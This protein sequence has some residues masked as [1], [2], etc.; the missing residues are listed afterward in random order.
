MP[1]HN[2]SFQLQRVEVLRSALA[3]GDAIRTSCTLNDSC[4]VYITRSLPTSAIATRN[5]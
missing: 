4:Y 1:R 3:D 5:Y 2:R